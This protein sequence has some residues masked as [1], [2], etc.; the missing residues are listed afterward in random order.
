MPTYE[1]A[2]RRVMIVSR[3]VLVWTLSHAEFAPGAGGIFHA[4]QANG[5]STL[6]SI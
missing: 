1:L 3:L 4:A 5:L 6:H 2:R